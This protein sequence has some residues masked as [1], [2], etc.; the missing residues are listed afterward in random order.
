MA[1]RISR[2]AYARFAKHLRARDGMIKPIE[3]RYK[4][5]R[6]RNRLEH[7]DRG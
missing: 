3:T 5:Y 2:T 4:G 6:F 1:M 7:G